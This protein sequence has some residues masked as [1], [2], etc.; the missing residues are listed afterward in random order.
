MIRTCHQHLIAFVQGTPGAAFDLD[1]LPQHASSRLSAAT[2]PNFDFP[3]DVLPANVAAT[4]DTRPWPAKSGP[5]KRTWPPAV[6]LQQ[7][8]PIPVSASATDADPMV[9]RLQASW[10]E[11]LTAMKSLGTPTS[12]TMAAIRC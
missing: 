12:S 8:R 6:R 4:I 9:G 10:S 5:G 3:M 7:N 2:A 1:A 11:G